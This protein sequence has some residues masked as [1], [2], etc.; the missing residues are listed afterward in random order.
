MRIIKEQ[1]IGLVIDIQERLLPHM[2]NNEDLLQNVKKLIAGLQVLDVP[3]LVTDQYRKGLG[4]SV[5]EL[6]DLFQPFESIEKV[7]FSCYGEPVFADKLKASGKKF[8]IIC[9]IESHVCVLQT[10]LDLKENGYIPVVVTDC[11]SSRKLSDKEIAM[12]RLIHEGAILTTSES[13]LFELT[14]AAGTDTFKAISKLV[15]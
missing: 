15:K 5:T 14:R 10:V 8:V 6:K 3:I 4:E 9:G 11:V 13:I 1:A 12:R 2:A 7:A